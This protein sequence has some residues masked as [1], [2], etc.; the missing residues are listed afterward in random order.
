MGVEKRQH[1]QSN[2][3]AMLGP[4]TEY[5]SC[6]ASETI[7]MQTLKRYNTAPMSYLMLEMAKHTFWALKC[8]IFRISFCATCGN[9]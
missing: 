2:K 5:I 9:M 7:N 8:I 4:Y 6:Q 1:V 3:D